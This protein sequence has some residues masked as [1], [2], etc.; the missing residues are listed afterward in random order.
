MSAN[1]EE[2]AVATGLEKINP[3]PNSQEGQ[4]Q[5]RF[6]PLDNCTPSPMLAR[7]CLKSCM[8]GFSIMPTKKFKMSTQ[9]LEKAEEP[10]IKLSIV[11]RS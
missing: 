10:E 4:Y 3:H 8:L 11:T 2:Q 6:K 7:S 9:G 1:L 5:R